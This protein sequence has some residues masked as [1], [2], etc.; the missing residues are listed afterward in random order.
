METALPVRPDSRD[1]HSIL[2]SGTP[3]IDVRAPVEFAQGHLDQAIN[4]PLMSDDERAVVGTCFK[5]KGQQAAI[6]LGHQLVNGANKAARVEAWRAFCLQ[7]PEGYLCCARGGLRSH[8]SQQWLRESGIDYP[9]IEGGYKALRSYAID[10][11][12]RLS[13]QPMILVSGNTG[14]GKTILIREQDTGI[15]LE[16][17]TRH[18][19]SSFGRMVDEQPSQA[20]FENH[21][22]TTLLQSWEKNRQLPGFAWVVEDE[23]RMIGSRHIPEV[24]RTKMQQSPIVVVEDPFEVRL[25]RLQEEYFAH[26][27]H[28]FIAAYGEEKGWEA[29]AEY[30]DHG[31]VAIQRRLGHARFAQF[32]TSLQAA[33]VHQRQTGDHSAHLSWLAPLLEE[34]YDPMYRYQLEKKAANIVFRGQYRE[35]AEW[36]EDRI[37]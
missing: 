13:E 36:L 34:Y 12:T 29:Y 25:A 3:L 26:M 7:H 30:L 22:G 14:N 8:I 19:G 28:N 24:W 18:R 1:Y 5:Q 16:G 10:T 35:V 27:T 31:L 2:L 20:S 33:L 4:L 32:Q 17:L 6:E 15:D 21:M 9:L 11:I 37:H 23:G